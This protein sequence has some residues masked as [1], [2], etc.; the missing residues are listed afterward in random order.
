MRKALENFKYECEHN[1]VKLITNIYLSKHISFPI[2]ENEDMTINTKDLEYPILIDVVVFSE[3]GNIA[4]KCT[5]EQLKVNCGGGLFFVWDDGCNELSC[6]DICAEN[7]VDTYNA[8]S[9]HCDIHDIP[10]RI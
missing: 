5:I 3:V 9:K 10:N 7:L 4:Q 1:I 8:L 2:W 6:V